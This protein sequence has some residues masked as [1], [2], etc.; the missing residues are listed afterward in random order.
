MNSNSIYRQFQL[1]LIVATSLFIIILSFIFYG[2]T[3]ATIYEDI[4]QDLLKDARLIYK[5]STNYT[6]NQ[7]TPIKIL[8]DTALM[9]DIV[10]INHLDQIAY[11]KYKVNNNHFIEILYPFDLTQHLFIKITKNIASVIF[12]TN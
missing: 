10:K 5:L 3:K 2:F 11:R 1:K 12:K 4:S 9:I 8:I 7:D 6:Q